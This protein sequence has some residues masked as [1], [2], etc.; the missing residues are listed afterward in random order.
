MVAERPSLTPMVQH[1]FFI[2]NFFFCM[3]K[4]ARARGRLISTQQMFYVSINFNLMTYCRWIRAT[5]GCGMYVCAL[6]TFIFCLSFWFHYPFLFSKDQSLL[7]LSHTPSI[8]SLPDDFYP[9]IISSWIY[10]SNL[11]YFSFE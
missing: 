11:E 2:I 3:N 5:V 6:C 8:F 4:W 9:F 10:S 7:F 1:F